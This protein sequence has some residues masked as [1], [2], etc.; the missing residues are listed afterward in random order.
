MVLLI[1]SFLQVVAELDPDEIFKP[2]TTFDVEGKLIQIKFML[3]CQFDMCACMYS[4]TRS[5]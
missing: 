1:Y 5:D 3:L 2:P 4:N